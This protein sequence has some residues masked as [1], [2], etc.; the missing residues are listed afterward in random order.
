[1]HARAVNS[2]TFEVY[3]DGTKIDRK[4]QLEMVKIGIV[5]DTHGAA[6]E[7]VL[8][9]L[10]GC[11]EIWHAGDIGNQKVVDK[12]GTIALFR[13][14]YGNIDDQD[15]RMQ[16]PEFQKFETNGAKVIITHIGGYPGKYQSK[17]LKEIADYQPQIV[18]CGHSHIL[19]VMFDK[20]NNCLFINPGAAGDS[21]FHH[22]KTAVRFNL[23]NGKSSDLEVFELP[24]R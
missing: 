18:V 6:D 16:C 1:L 7:K 3:F 23:D 21:G 22:V 13:G 14:V 4:E 9:F 11:S 5:S 10:S 19:K 15:M 2:I 20:K 24:R 12:L 17:L 8:D